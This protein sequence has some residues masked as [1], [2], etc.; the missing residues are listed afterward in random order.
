MDGE[1]KLKTIFLV[2]SGVLRFNAVSVNLK[3]IQNHSAQTTL[4][5]KTGSNM[6]QV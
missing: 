1:K 5:T 4:K 6:N 3:F 2:C